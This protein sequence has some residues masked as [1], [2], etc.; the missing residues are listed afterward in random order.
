MRYDELIILN[1]RDKKCVENFV[2]ERS[3]G[4]QE[5]RGLQKII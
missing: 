1:G 3:H 4:N 2:G 5:E